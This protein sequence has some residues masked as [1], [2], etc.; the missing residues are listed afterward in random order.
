MHKRSVPIVAALV[1][2]APIWGGPLS[3]AAP[4]AGGT[5][6]IEPKTAD[7]DYDRS[8]PAFVNAAADALATKGFT[9]LEDPGHSAYVVELILSRVAVG[10]TSAK[11]PSGKPSV[12][13]GGPGPSVGA[14]VV[15]PLGS[16]VAQVPVLRTRLELRIRKRGADGV[17]WDGAAV[18]VRAAGTKTGA[19]APVAA[20]LSEAVLR[21]YP[22]QPEGDAGVP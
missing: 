22:A 8:M 13:G 3:A 2:L 20:A 4:P 10:T 17:V 11:T 5:I 16:G 6:S 15:F 9:I 7:G 18:T 14:G 19:D 21:S 12:G 1:A